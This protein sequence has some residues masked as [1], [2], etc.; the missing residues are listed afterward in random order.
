MAVTD[1]F[2]STLSNLTDDIKSTGKSVGNVAAS[3]KPYASKVLAKLNTVGKS[4]PAK[5]VKSVG[6][7]LIDN[8]NVIPSA[9]AAGD[10]LGMTFA[11]DAGMATKIGGG[12]EALGNVSAGFL[13][14]RFSAGKK[15]A[16]TKGGVALGNSLTDFR[17]VT[18]LASWLQ[19]GGDTNL[20]TM[21]KMLNGQA[22]KVVAANKASPKLPQNDAGKDLTSEPDDRTP[23][24]KEIDSGGLT[25]S[26]EELSIK[27]RA[28][29]GEISEEDAIKMLEGLS[30]QPA[31]GNVELSVP[32]QGS[33][34]QADPLAGIKNTLLQQE[35]TATP[36]QQ[37]QAEVVNVSEADPLAEIRN[38]IAQAQEAQDSIVNPLQQENQVQLQDYSNN[39]FAAV[40][41]LQNVAGQVNK[42][43]VD[44]KIAKDSAKS[45]LEN[46]QKQAGVVELDNSLKNSAFNRKQGEEESKN[47]KIE[48]DDKLKNSEFDRKKGSLD[49]DKSMVELSNTLKN[50]DLS[51]EKTGQ[52]I[53]E[54]KIKLDQS[55]RLNDAMTKLGTLDDTT[56]PKGDKRKV[57]QE[58]IL[59]MLG[60][61]PKDN[62]LIQEVGGGIDPITG[63]PLPK[64]AV[65]F[66][67]YTGRIISDAGGGEAGATTTK[68]KPKI[69]AIKNVAGKNYEYRTS[70]DGTGWHNDNGDLIENV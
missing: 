19:G 49:F 51:R 29:R 40:M 16:I 28:A 63:L 8:L 22:Q 26:P 32:A 11:S 46:A 30:K 24:E 27:S 31:Q 41:Q 50:S 39:P 69:G 15:S 44:N 47:K 70:A 56:D 53:Q 61:E 3:A 6:S 12:L 4:K 65:V 36:P 2:K 34:A 7:G 42:Y 52:D 45:L 37:P 58:T 54:G 20:M 33:V 59:T 1:M 35:P 38:T 43:A 57:L 9:I 60:K 5:A 25:G 55:K 64:R 17:P 62:Y 67:K 23:V 48:L 10:D 66:D 21:R 14:D 68:T 18:Q 13:A